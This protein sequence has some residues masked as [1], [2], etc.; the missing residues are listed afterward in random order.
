MAEECV[1]PGFLLKCAAAIAVEIMSVTFVEIN[2]G[3]PAHVCHQPKR[4]MSGAQHP[5]HNETETAR[6]WTIASLTPTI[7]GLFRVAP[8]ALVSE[9]MLA[10]IRALSDNLLGNN[11]ISRCLVF[12]PD[13]LGDHL[14]SQHQEHVTAIA[15]HCPQR[16]PLSSVF[17]PITPVCFSSVFTGAPPGRHGVQTPDRRPLACDT[18]FD[19]LLRAGKRVAIVAVEGSSIDRLFRSRAIDYFSEAYDGQVTERV[20][21]LF[22][23]DAHDLIVVYHQEYDDRLHETHPFS[24]QCLKALSSHVRS[25]REFAQGSRRAW[26]HH[27][28]AIVMAPD[29]GAHVDEATGRG[30]HGLDIPEDMAVSHWYGIYGDI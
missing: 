2:N 9:P 27:R 7:C 28:Y 8:P 5:L 11:A 21:A 18:L 16:V 20:F 26:A 4:Y 13:A 24:E 29:H 22:S 30:D 1:E 6:E 19:A 15:A 17:P 3:V 10:P 14:W 23:A 12:C 25:L